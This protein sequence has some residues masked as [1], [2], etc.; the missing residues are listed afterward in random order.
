MISGSE[1]LRR[2]YISLA[3]SFIFGLILYF[4]LTGLYSIATTMKTFLSIS[5]ILLVF[6]VTFVTASVIIE[7]RSMSES[8]RP[9][10]LIGGF[11]VASIVT[12]LFVCASNGVMMAVKSGLPP[13]EEF[14]LYISVLS[15]VAFTILKLIE[16]SMKRY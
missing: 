6:A 15:A 7:H 16:N 1:V 10:Y 14:L 2:V 12:F 11:V 13:V 8:G 5:Y 3:I 9:Y 4:M